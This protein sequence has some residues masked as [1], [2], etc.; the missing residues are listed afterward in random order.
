MYCEKAY[1]FNILQIK[2]LFMKRLYL[3]LNMIK[4]TTIL[5]DPISDQ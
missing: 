3:V 4:L 5:K 2:L 1:K